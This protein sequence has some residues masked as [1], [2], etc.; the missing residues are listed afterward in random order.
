MKKIKYTSYL[1]A[2]KATEYILGRRDITIVNEGYNTSKV[3][4]LWASPGSQ[5][6]EKAREFTKSLLEAADL[7][8][9]INALDVEIDYNTKDMTAEE[10][11]EELE[12]WIEFLK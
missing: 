3:K 12:K 1:L 8:D 5:N 2:L 4:I 11:K 7:A 10:I 9:K 6:P